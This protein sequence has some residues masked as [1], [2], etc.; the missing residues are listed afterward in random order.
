[1]A[2]VS[3]PVG[4]PATVTA[5]ASAAHPDRID[6]ATLV[7][8]IASAREHAA[9]QAAATPV[10]VSLAHADFGPVAL[11]F[12]HEGDAL[13]VTMASA[14][15]SFAPAVSAAAQ[16]SGNNQPQS[17]SFGASTNQGSQQTSQ[18]QAGSGQASSGQ[19]GSGQNH[20][21]QRQP[22]QNRPFPRTAARTAERD[23]PDPDIFA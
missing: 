16:Q 11:R 4:N 5:P 17:S 22:A 13:A 12:R 8:T 18:G 2:A 19:A 14:D 1:M 7:N 9:P 3:Q 15:P 20:A 21:D 6:F 10:S 23:G